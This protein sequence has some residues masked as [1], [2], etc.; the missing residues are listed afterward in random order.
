MSKTTPIGVRVSLETKDALARAAKDDLRSMASL[1]EKILT[2]W[3]KENGYA[4]EPSKAPTATR[5]RRKAVVL[6]AAA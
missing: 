3:L 6:G 4:P 1:V 2:D 5:Q